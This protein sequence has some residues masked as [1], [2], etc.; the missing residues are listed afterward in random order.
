MKI[1][2][3]IPFLFDKKNKEDNIKRIISGKAFYVK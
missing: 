3:V 2:K 1:I